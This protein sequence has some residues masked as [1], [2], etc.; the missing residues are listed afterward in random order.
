MKKRRQWYYRGSLKSCN[1]SCSYC[2]FSKKTGSGKEWERDKE[3]FFQFILRLEELEEKGAV[4]IVPYGEAL[5]HA[6]YW[7]GLARLS[8]MCSLDAV[9]AQ[10]NFSFPVEKML[11]YYEQQGGCMEKLR[12]WGTF[13]PEMTSV[14]AF[15][16]QCRRLSQWKVSYCVGVVGVP[17]QITKIQELREKLDDSVYLWINKMDGLG[18]NYSEE[19]QRSFQEIDA[20]FPLELQQHRAN[21]TVCG[22]QIFVQ[23]DGRMARCN[24]CRATKENLYET[25]PESDKLPCTRRECSCY[26]AYNN[27]KEKDLLFFEPYP[28]FRIP[29]YPKAVFLDVDGT[30]LPEGERSL[31]EE[32]IQKVKGLARHSDVYLATTLPAEDALRKVRGIR[33][34]LSG[35]VF[36]D[37]GRCILLKKADSKPEDEKRVA[38]NGTNIAPVKDWIAPLD[39]AWLEQAKQ[40]QKQYGFHLHIYQ[41]EQKIYKVTLSFPRSHCRN[42]ELMQELV[43]KIR[44]DWKIPQSCKC[45]VEENCIQIVRADRGKL[46]GILE[47]LQIMKYDKESV[48]VAGNS[49]QDEE[50][51]DAFSNSV[52]VLGDAVIWR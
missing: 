15:I 47:I 19:E 21:E 17:E 32:T 52:R 36:A 3:Q 38:G 42:P 18:R 10:S 35:G 22:N 31:S 27:C 4:Q 48:M 26:L 11:S 14:D 29:S 13:H 44:A 51:L 24:L 34:Y 43:Q 46:A 28:A 40:G 12:L 6:Y 20:Y 45:F 7:E 39:A 9:G 50:M 37:G 23:A 5:I 30:L 16:K 25:I 2:P 33:Q 41:R 1:Y 49:K 8:K